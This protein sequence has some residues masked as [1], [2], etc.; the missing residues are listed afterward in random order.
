MNR[1]VKILYFASLSEQLNTREE[2][3]SLPAA[4]RTLAQLRHLLSERYPKG[5]ALTASN[6]RF[7]ANHSL[8]NDNYLLADGDEIAFFPPVTG[9]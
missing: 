6:I 7:A 2:T 1:T 9:G 4:I 3:L 5:A 8:V